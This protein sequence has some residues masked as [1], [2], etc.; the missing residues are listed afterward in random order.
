MDPE[1]LKFA[2]SEE[3]QKGFSRILGSLPE[4]TLLLGIIGGNTC[5]ILRQMEYITPKTVQAVARSALGQRLWLLVNTYEPPKFDKG[6][7]AIEESL[8]MSRM[9]S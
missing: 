8:Y 1:I 3:S 5:K 2:L 4:H 9:I 6:I 7:D